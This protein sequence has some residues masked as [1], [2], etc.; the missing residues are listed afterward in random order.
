MYN[1]RSYEKILLEKRESAN[2]SKIYFF[3]KANLKTNN[4]TKI[5]EILNYISLISKQIYAVFL[6][7]DA[8]I[9]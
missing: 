4:S 5:S 6:V 2:L 3:P 8:A 1:S 9:L 7:K